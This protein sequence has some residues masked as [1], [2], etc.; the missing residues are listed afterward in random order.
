MANPARDLEFLF[1]LGSLGP[2]P[3]GWRQHL[4]MECAS[5]LEHTMRVVFL[6]L[7]IARREGGCDEAKVMKMALLHDLAESRTSDL[8]YMQ[9]V[10]VAADEP[11]AATDLFT[12]TA[13][14][15]FRALHEEYEGRKSREAKIV[16]DADNL[17]IDLELKEL[18]ERGSQLPA[19]WQHFRQKIRDEKFYMPAAK[20][21][22]D[23]VQTADPA[24]WHLT[25]N[26]WM[27]L[28]NAGR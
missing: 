10:Y 2:M 19:K 27:K 25:A 21:L 22:W 11:R 14:E 6:A 3:R 4:G 24:A 16:K 18:A 15:D 23:R 7:L 28:P 12:G 26:K 20:E 5:V 9:K 13:W 1:E 17:D 8:S